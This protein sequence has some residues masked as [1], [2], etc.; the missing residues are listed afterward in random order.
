MGLNG[1]DIAS[2]QAGLDPAK[3]PC[4]FVIVKATQGTG[5]TN[6]DFRR[7]AD[8]VL[9][10]GKLLGI[11]HYAGGGTHTAEAAHFLD[12]TAPYL[13]KATLWLDWE[14]EQN[15][16]FGRSD[17]S[18]CKAFCNYVKQQAGIACG[19]YMSKSVCRAH[20]WS[21]LSGDC[22]LWAAQYA[23]MDRT[24]YQP[25]PWT[26]GQGFGAWGAPSI[27]QYSSRGCLG[28]WGGNLDLDLAYMTREEWAAMAAGGGAATDAGLFPG[29]TDADLAVEILFNA[30]GT[31][32]A[33]KKALG[34]RY[35]GAQGE[36][37]RLLD[38]NKTSLLMAVQSYLKRHGHDNL[39]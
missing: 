7:A 17:V 25:S 1:I 11:Y 28:G 3:V 29:M 30:H 13:G 2:Y 38:R 10:A 19:I 15:S 37:N 16:A 35:A 6:P 34:G 4:D 12:V 39:I 20:D 32:D 8:A 33:R 14:G 9:A 21:G 23:N 36:V 27:Y 5:Y 18:W 22:P 26:D 31:G 24:G